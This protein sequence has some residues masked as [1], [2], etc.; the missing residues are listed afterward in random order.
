MLMLPRQKG[1]S[2]QYSLRKGKKEQFGTTGETEGDD[3]Y[4]RQHNFQK[5]G[6]KKAW[7]AKPDL[8]DLCK[9]HEGLIDQILQEEEDLTG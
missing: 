7:D 4:S 6:Q 8:M 3:E 5:S 9:T 2:K 1:N